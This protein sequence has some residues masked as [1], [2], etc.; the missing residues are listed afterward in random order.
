MKLRICLLLH[1]SNLSIPI[2]TEVAEVYG[3]YF[4]KKEHTIYAII[5]STKSLEYE[6][7]GIHI[8]EVPY[9][10]KFRKMMFTQKIIKEKNCNLIQVRNSALDGLI[11][12]YIKWKYRI[13]LLF[14]YTWPAF[15][16]RKEKARLKNSNRIYLDGLTG[17]FTDFL[18]MIVMRRSD[19]VLPISK[20]MKKYLVYRG[21]SES[22]MYIFSDG[23]NPD[24]FFPKNSRM[25]KRREYGLRSSPT[26]VYIGTMDELRHLD[27]LIYS[28]KRIKEKLNKAKLMMVGDG[29]DRKNLEVLA[30]SLKVHENIIFTGR[31]PYSEVPLFI[32]ASDIAVSP[33]PPLDLYK[34][35]SPLKLFEY[36]GVAKPVV[37][38]E[39]I[40][41]HREVIQESGGGILVSYDEESFANAI[42]ALLNDPEQCKIMG[43][44]GRDWVLEN[45]SYEKFAKKLEKE[46]FN[47][48]S[49]TKCLDK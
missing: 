49:I 23:V 5:S 18:Q 8:Y 48:L 24:I 32:A 36:M 25:E 27:V 3:G 14:Q 47:L 37:A 41:E 42:I 12:L 16:A 11:G 21:I 9:K 35:S 39:E 4:I 17:K 46:Y 31:V 13:P 29:N 34:V 2:R 20:W 7:R 43:R 10:N 1:N 26:I 38:N 30:K 6:W 19:L 44:K 28:F 45:R 40:P 22:K 15:E 33:I